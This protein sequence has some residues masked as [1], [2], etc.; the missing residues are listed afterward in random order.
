VLF[1]ADTPHVADGIE[2]YDVSSEGDV[3]YLPVDGQEAS[4]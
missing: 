3:V 4:A 1:G 2:L